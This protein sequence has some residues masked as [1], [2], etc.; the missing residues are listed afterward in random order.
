[1]QEGV[2]MTIKEFY[3]WAKENN[4]ENYD[5]KICDDA[6]GWYY[7]QSEEQIYSAGLTLA[8]VFG[9]DYFKGTINEI[10]KGLVKILRE[11]KEGVNNVNIGEYK[12]HPD[13]FNYA[14]NHEFTSLSKKDAYR[15]LVYVC[16]YWD[17]NEQRYTYGNKFL[18]F[19]INMATHQSLC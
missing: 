13:A 12:A 5:I 16:S 10:P 11:I 4:V 2:S 6:Y 7:S 1:M 14:F 15:F 3:E 9:N 17:R 19:V 18:I 8:G